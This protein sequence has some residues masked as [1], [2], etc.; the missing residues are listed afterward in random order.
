M[1][2]VDEADE[3]LEVDDMRWGDCVGSSVLAGDAWALLQL[4]LGSI[5]CM[6]NDDESDAE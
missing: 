3:E 4:L 5:K 2:E 6:M 1:L